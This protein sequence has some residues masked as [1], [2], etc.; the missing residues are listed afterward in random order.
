MSDAIRSTF[1]FSQKQLDKKEIATIAEALGIEE[2]TNFISPDPSMTVDELD[3][4][5]NDF[6][7]VIFADYDTHSLYDITGDLENFLSFLDNY[8]SPDETLSNAIMD[9]LMVE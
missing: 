3:I 6:D 8:A 9:Y 7:Q 2:D 4:D 1:I 5:L